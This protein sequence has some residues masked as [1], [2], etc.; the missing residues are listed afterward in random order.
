MDTDLLTESLRGFPAVLAALLADVDDE[1]ARERPAG[2]SWAPVEIARHLLDEE[3]RDF[4]PRLLRTLEGQPWEP[5]DPEGWAARG[6]YLG[7][8]LAR[9]LSDF[10]G[11]R[12]RSMALLDSLVRP[13]WG[14]THHH[15]ALGPITAGDLL[16]SWAAHDA[17]HLAQVARARVALLARAAEPHGVG[18]AVG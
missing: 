9:T 3:R 12:S 5:I 6:A 11:E 10:E 7:D 1:R 13:D 2:D 8:S 16:A 15:P 14:A 18:Y 4:L 17:L